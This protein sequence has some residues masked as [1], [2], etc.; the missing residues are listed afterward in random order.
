ME[1]LKRAGFTIDNKPTI[2][3]DELR[4]IV[5]NYDVLIVRSRTK[6][7]GRTLAIGTRLKAIGRAG[8]G[9]DNIDVETAQKKGVRILNTPEAAAEAVAELTIGLLLSL[10]RNIPCADLAMKEKKWI[11]MELEGWELRG[12]VLGTIGLGNVG[13][14]VA[15]LAKAFGMKILVNKRTP[16]SPELLEELGAQFVPLKSLLAHSDIVTVHIPYSIETHH[17]IGKKELSLMKKD[18]YMIN[19]SRGPVID[20]EA[21]LSALQSGRLRGAALDVFEVEPPTNWMLAQLPSV[22]CTPHIGAQTIEA[23]RAA[24]LLLAEKLISALL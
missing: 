21:L 17:M 19:T 5:S 10:A 9:L 12:K 3:A 7:D 15:R 8:V 1:K 14:R 24:A 22:V 2:S 16:P 6:V 23:Q 4:K 13:E 11:K 20:E 18:G